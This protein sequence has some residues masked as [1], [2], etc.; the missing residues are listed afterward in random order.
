MTNSLARDGPQASITLSQ[1]H[2]NM[3]FTNPDS[4]VII[5]GVEINITESNHRVA[6][7]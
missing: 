7:G 1:P 3:L 4:R 2:Q 6:G 5:T